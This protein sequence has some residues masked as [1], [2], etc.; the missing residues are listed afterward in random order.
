MKK[1]KNLRL[2]Y[3]DQRLKTWANWYTHFLTGHLGYAQIPIHQ[4]MLGMDIASGRKQSTIP[5]NPIAESVEK[6]LSVLRQQDEQLAKV[7]IVHYAYFGCYEDRIRY[8]G[9]SGARFSERLK[10]GKCWLVGWF[11]ANGEL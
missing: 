9:L 8:V 10:Q 2:L 5:I 6:A 3:V 11:T 7:L 1:N 4:L